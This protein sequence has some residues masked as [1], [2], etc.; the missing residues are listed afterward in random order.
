MNRKRHSQ[1]QYSGRLWHLNYHAQLVLTSITSAKK[2]FPT[3]LHH[4]W[5]KTGWFYRFM[6]F[7]SH[8][9]PSACHSKKQDC[10]DELKF[11]QSSAVQRWWVCAHCS[12]SFIADRN[13]LRSSTAEVL[14]LQASMHCV[15]RDACLLSTVGMPIYLS[16]CCLP[17]S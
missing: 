16:Y 13:L 6:L 10:S 12:L 17:V 8:S 14:P 3:S 1:Q 9:D 4:Q 2:I 7:T 11:L 15:C 5:H